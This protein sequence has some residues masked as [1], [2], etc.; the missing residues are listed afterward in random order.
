MLSYFGEK[1]LVDVN[2]VVGAISKTVDWVFDRVYQN[3]YIFLT[4]SKLVHLQTQDPGVDGEQT[5]KIR[6]KTDLQFLNG[7]MSK[8]APFFGP[9]CIFQVLYEGSK[10]PKIQQK[11]TINPLKRAKNLKHRKSTC[12]IVNL[13]RN[14]STSPI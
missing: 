10:M 9:P 2:T 12:F 7:S 3:Q 5:V 14:Y 1:L 11:I 4:T 6:I 13:V 8:L